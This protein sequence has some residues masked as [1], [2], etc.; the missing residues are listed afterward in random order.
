MYHICAKTDY[1]FQFDM[2]HIV[3]IVGTLTGAYCW[4]FHFNCI[5]HIPLFI[6]RSR[7]FPIPYRFSA[8]IYCFTLT[9][10]LFN[11]SSNR[12]KI[13]L[14]IFYS[15]IFGFGWIPFFLAEVT[16]KA[17]YI[18]HI[19]VY[20]ICTMIGTILILYLLHILQTQVRLQNEL[21]NAEKFHLIGEM[22]FYLS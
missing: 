22:A 8:S 21:M 11:R 14:A 13:A 7:C 10:K 18:P 12:I 1:G 16:N 17:D 2:R 19:I 4:C 3:L 5:K 15:L 6:R 9:Y 20:E